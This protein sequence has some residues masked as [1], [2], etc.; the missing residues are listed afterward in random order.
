MT[1]FPNC[2]TDEYYNE[3][4]LN[5]QDAEFIRGYDWAVKEILNLFENNV[6]VFPEL[7]RLLDDK[8]AII[9]EGKANLVSECIEHWSEM[10]RDELITSMIDGMEEDEYNSIKAKVDREQKEE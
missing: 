4:Y 3:K 9:C 7:E 2:R 1:W 5:E 8:T 6:E 10:E